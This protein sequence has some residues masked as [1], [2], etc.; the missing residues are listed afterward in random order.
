MKTRNYVLYALYLF[1]LALFI[2]SC[3]S[4]TSGQG[5]EGA[6]AEEPT[7][8]IAQGHL[9]VWNEAIAQVME[10]ADAMEENQYSYRPHDSIRTFGEQ[11]V[12]IGGSSKMLANLFLKDIPIPQDQPEMD[13]SSMNK[14]EIKDFVRTQL[15]ETGAIFGSLSDQQLQ[16]E[17]KSF[18]GKAMTRLEGMLMVHDHL[19]NHKAKANLYVRISGNQPP[20]YRYY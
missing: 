6:Q 19:T 5:D 3:T 7:N 11:L 18:S 12:H 13:V 4:G 9:K 10:L 20:S 14:Q 8:A 17:I 15:E 1:P 16:E 2:G